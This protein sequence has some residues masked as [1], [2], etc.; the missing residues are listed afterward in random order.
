METLHFALDAIWNRYHNRDTLSCIGETLV[1]GITGEL[2]LEAHA[3]LPASQQIVQKDL[4]YAFL[5][6]FL[7]RIC[8]ILFSNQIPHSVLR[9]LPEMHSIAHVIL[10]LATLTT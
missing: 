7:P 1:K 4:S 3:C 9:K 6:S 10:S 2:L 8:R 5:W